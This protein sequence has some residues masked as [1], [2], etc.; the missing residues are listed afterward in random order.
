MKTNYI[1][2]T[3]NGV[4][5]KKDTFYNYLNTLRDH[6]KRLNSLSNNI[7]QVTIMK[8][9]SNINN[10]YYD[11]EI[12]DNIKIIECENEYFSYGQWLKALKLFL[13][14][15][16]YYILIEDDYVPN[17]HNFDQKLIELYKE[18]TYLCS[19]VGTH[20][21][22]GVKF[23]FH[24]RISNGII[25]SNT[26]KNIINNVDYNKWFLKYGDYQISFSR[27]LFENGIDLVDYTDS[28]M[29]DYYAYGKI[30][31]YSNPDCINKEKIFTPIQ[32][33]I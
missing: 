7:S 12:D 16:D 26:I 13:T 18:N 8:P 29:V 10:S 27:Y 23:P 19:L 22:K 17:T 5:V 14:D 21:A 20:E 30:Q 4:R 3:W 2:A 1:I 25:S 6:L 9:E 28:Y 24:C 31:D 33:I 32:N 15:F 11:I